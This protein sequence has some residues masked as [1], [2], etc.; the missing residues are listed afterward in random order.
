MNDNFD[1]VNSTPQYEITLRAI[2]K[3][4]EYVDH[5][6]FRIADLYEALTN[7]FNL[8]HISD[9]LDILSKFI[10][11]YCCYIKNKAKTTPGEE[12][13]RIEKKQNNLILFYILNLALKNY[14]F[15]YFQEKFISYIHKK[16]THNT[17]NPSILHRMVS[18]IEKLFPSIEEFNEKLEDL[19]FAYFFINNKYFDFAQK[20]LNIYN[21]HNISSEGRDTA[22]IIDK[23]GFRLLGSFILLRYSIEI[24]KGIKQGYIIY[25]EEK[26][27]LKADEKLEVNNLKLKMNKADNFNKNVDDK[28]CLLCMDERKYTSLTICGHLFCWTCITQY[29]QV[30][31]SCPFCRAVCLP[32]Q[33]IFLQN[34]N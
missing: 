25:K 32:Q 6:S 17:H 22:Q 9:K 14:L 18:R 4:N 27:N 28:T 8:S 7:F 2:Q 20:I 13:T 33:V 23:S 31:Q 34:Y 5:L 30:K 1:K 11:Y 24:Y 15:K 19:Q 21:V 29:L 26:H 3:D 16:Y 12:Y 10:F